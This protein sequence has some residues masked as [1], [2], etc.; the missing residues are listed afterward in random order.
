M[1]TNAKILNTSSNMRIKRS[2]ALRR[3]EQCISTWVDSFT[4]HDL[5]LA[6]RVHARS[7]KAR[8]E[9]ALAFAELP[10]L[11]FQ[12]PAYAQESTRREYALAAEANK[13]VVECLP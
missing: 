12:P 3:V 10:G 8:L 7:E 4:I 13:F 11:K 5:S 2:Q 9:E 6:E 1:G